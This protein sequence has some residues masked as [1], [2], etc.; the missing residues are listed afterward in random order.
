MG[1]DSY[2][3]LCATTKVI[4]IPNCRLLSLIVVVLW[5]FEEFNLFDCDLI[6]DYPVTAFWCW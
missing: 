6:C 2:S 1:I 4:S 3:K 5:T